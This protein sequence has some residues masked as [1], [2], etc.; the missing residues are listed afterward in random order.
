M[1]I[2]LIDI[3]TL[4][5]K[6]FNS[7]KAPPYAILSHT[8]VE[9]EEISF[10][11]MCQIS[12]NPN[13]PAANMSGYRKIE[14]T[15]R[16]AT[17]HGLEYAWVDTCCI[18]KSSSAELSEA[19]NSMFRW[20]RD[21]KVCFAYL[22]DFSLASSD[23]DLMM[24]PHTDSSFSNDVLYISSYDLKKNSGMEGCK[25][26]TRGWCLQELIAPKHMIFYNKAWLEVGTKSTLMECITSITR[27]D[28]NVLEDHTDMYSLPVARRMSW[29]SGR[30]TTRVEDI[31]YCLLGIFD[32]N[33][34]MLYGEGEKAFSRLQ[35]EITRRFNDT[36]IF[37]FSPKK[38]PAQISYSPR[39]ATPQAKG[40]R[41]PGD[42]SLTPDSKASHMTNLKLSATEYVEELSTYQFCDMFANSPA[43]FDDCG[44]IVYKPGSR[45]LFDRKAF[46]VTNRGVQLGEHLLW[47]DWGKYCFI[48][49]TAFHHS[50]YINHVSNGAIFLRKIGRNLFTR[51]LLPRADISSA[52]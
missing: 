12:E 13:H 2:R 31:A 36:S 5:L 46:S 19:I 15:C 24:K 3:K 6:S 17:N 8:W 52:R 45:A 47:C 21:A 29:A 38:L 30:I 11:E 22:S 23:L 43:D 20:Y 49:E 51:V 18:D 32:I 28:K 34:P 1:S 40:K 33:M 27:V 25:W 39:A 9:D 4:R 37:L 10:Q 41:K 7:A 35:E 44:D 26:F 14:E 48:W 42:I 16:L 50:N